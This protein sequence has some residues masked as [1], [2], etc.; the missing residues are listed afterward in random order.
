MIQF[1]EQ[2]FEQGNKH[3]FTEMELYYQSTNRFNTQLFNGEVDGYKVSSEGG[4]SFRGIYNGK[5]GYAYTEKIADSEIEFLIQEAAD[6]ALIIEDDNP[7]EL[8]AGSDSYADISLYSQSLSEVSSD[9]KINLLKE[10]EK[11]CYALS[12]LIHS[13]NYC[14]LESR[15][16]ETFIANTKGLEKREK[17]NFIYII[18]SAV[19]K[20]GDEFKSAMKYWVTDDFSTFSP[21]EMAKEVVDEAL[22]FVGA[23]SIKSGQ[24]PIILRNTAASSL[25]QVFSSSFSA[26]DVQKGKSLLAGKLNE[27]IGHSLITIIDDP[28]DRNGVASQTFDG[29]GVA[30]AKQTIVENGVLLTYLHNSKTAQKDGVK[31]T[32]HAY[33]PSYKGSISISPSNMY[34]QPGSESL[35][36]LM[37]S[38]SET[39]VITD[40]QGLH[41]GANSITGDFSLAANG[42]LV[43]NGKIERP[44]DQITVAGNFFTLL[45]QVEAIGNDLDFSIM[46]SGYLGSPSLKVGTL[47]V[48]GE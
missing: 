17:R 45:N 26:D 1:K 36:Q 9:D 15:E 25:L 34:I 42:Y 46:G 40:L 13:I 38:E 47:S 43:R 10:A 35:Q 44:L 14:T 31:S 22:S 41:S 20:S 48:G 28:H 2:L 3:G 7:E 39:I 30:T 16:S 8:F 32:G 19:V 29:E 5:M 18:L 21:K 33:K 23:S 12:D 24:Y 6:N 4:V 11:E 37:E 27:T